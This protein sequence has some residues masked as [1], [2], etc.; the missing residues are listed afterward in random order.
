MVDEVG[1]HGILGLEQRVAYHFLG[2]TGVSGIDVASGLLERAATGFL[3]QRL[4][5]SEC[6][7]MLPE[8]LFPFFQPAFPDPSLAAQHLD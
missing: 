2:K 3:E 8:R 4:V 5:E 6:I 7:A 1:S